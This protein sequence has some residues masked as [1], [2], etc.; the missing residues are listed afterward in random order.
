MKL[1]SNF[2][3]NFIRELESLGANIYEKTNHGIKI[4]YIMINN[5]L[6]NNIIFVLRFKCVTYSC[7]RRLTYFFILF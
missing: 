2:Q 7:L 6:N 5:H 3:K 1:I 4:F